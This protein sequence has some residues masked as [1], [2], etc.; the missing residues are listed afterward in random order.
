MHSLKSDRA[1]PSARAVAWIIAGAALASLTLAPSGA[2]SAE[3]LKLRPVVEHAALTPS[4]VEARTAFVI[5][6]TLR[7]TFFERFGEDL[8]GAEDSVLSSLVERSELTGEY[9]IQQDGFIFLPLI[10]PTQTAMLTSPQLEDALKNRFKELFNG[11]VAVAIQLTAREPVYV[12]GAIPQPGHF[13]YVPGMTVMHALALAGASDRIDGDQWRQLDLVRE[14]ERV[15]QAESRL[16][17]VLARASVLADETHRNSSRLV[18]QL[19]SVA[20]PRAAEDLQ[21]EATA[22]R[23]LERKGVEAR[24]VARE[25]ILTSLIAERALVEQSVADSEETMMEKIERVAVMNDLRRR[26][27]TT[28][29]NVHVARS[30]L[31]NARAAWNELRA[32][33]TRI[34]RNIT[35]VRLQERDGEIEQQIAVERELQTLRAAVAQEEATRSSLAQVLARV[36]TLDPTA[37]EEEGGHMRME[38]VRRTPDGLQH[39]QAHSFTEMHPGDML[40]IISAKDERQTAGL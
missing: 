29:Q 34:E 6:D 35:E 37:M 33:M 25:T 4:A 30:E 36:A 18:E 21:A 10:G 12:A 9:V 17:G 26:G 27:A 22:L 7:I 1:S 31:S 5:G 24:R 20:G 23:D 15:R 19:L 14:R 32:A 13:P 8:G 11:D 40:N 38:I 3:D 16:K 39:I 2:I 28:D